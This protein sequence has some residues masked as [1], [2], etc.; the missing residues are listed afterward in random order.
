MSGPPCVFGPIKQPQRKLGSVLFIHEK[1][2]QVRYNYRL[3]PIALISED[4]LLISFAHSLKNIQ[5]NCRKTFTNG[6]YQ[7]RMNMPATVH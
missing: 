5:W 7:F 1:V 3:S 4:E 2:T 6:N